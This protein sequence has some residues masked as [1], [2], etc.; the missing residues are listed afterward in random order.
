M[1]VQFCSRR[2]GYSDI[3]SHLGE[4]RKKSP[5]Q[6]KIRRL[7]RILQSAPTKCQGQNRKDLL[8]FNGKS[9]LG[10]RHNEKSKA[11]FCAQGR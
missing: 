9:G 3:D 4:F 7:R 2:M 11:I 5:A 10:L 1:K 6:R 8:I